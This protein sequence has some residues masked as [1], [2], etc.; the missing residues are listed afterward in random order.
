M[1]SRV[2]KRSENSGRTD[3]N[4]TSFNKR[5]DTFNNETMVV[6]RMFDKQ[7]LLRKVDASKGIEEIF[8]DLKRL[9]VD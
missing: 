6:L 9:F 7:G 3:D 1:L 2:M 8:S 4:V 5:F